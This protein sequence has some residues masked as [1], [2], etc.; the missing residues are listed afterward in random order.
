MEG[1][2]KRLEEEL[3][4]A[5]TEVEVVNKERKAAQTGVEAEMKRLEERWRKGV[6]RVL[7]VEVAAE[8]MRRQILE[9]RRE[10]R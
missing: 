9:K 7:E 1:I 5:K 4:A 2:L 3:M 6:G 8:A 10:G